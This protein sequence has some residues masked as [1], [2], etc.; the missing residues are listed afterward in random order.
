MMFSFL[1]EN[2]PR[3]NHYLVYNTS[4]ECNSS[5]W[6]PPN[7]DVTEIVYAAYHYQKQMGIRST[8]KNVYTSEILKIYSRYFDHIFLDFFN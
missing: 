5:Q 1:N 6:Q 2:R 7:E 8:H 3:T 4:G